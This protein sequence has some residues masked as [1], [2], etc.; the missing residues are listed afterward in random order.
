MVRFLFVH[1]AMVTPQTTFLT[2]EWYDKLLEELNLLKKDKLPTVLE[3]LKEAISQWDISE[4]AEY[5]TAMSEKEL[6]EARIAEIETI[7]TNVEIIEMEQTKDGGEV[8]Y[9]S[10]VTVMDDKKREYTRTIVGSGEVDIFNNTISFQSPLGHALRGK[11]VG[12]TVQVRAPQ[13]KYSV[14]ITS[15][16]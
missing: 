4:N 2:K 5:D 10:K 9:W 11:R 16:K 7:L 13:K 1:T 3:R 6:I 12:D 14:T 8:R 15:I